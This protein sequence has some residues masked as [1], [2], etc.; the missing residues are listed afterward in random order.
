MLRM[1][2]PH[3]G[4]RASVSVELAL[5]SVLF[6]LPLFGG[7]ADLTE[8]IS[9]QAQANTALRALYSFAW[10]D[11]ADASTYSNANSI[12]GLINS[13]SIHPLS[14]SQNSTIAVQEVGQP[15]GTTIPVTNGSFYYVC[16]PTGATAG[17]TLTQSYSNP[18]PSSGYT[19]QI[20]AAYQVTST[21]FLPVPMPFVTN[22]QFTV[23]AMGEVQV[24]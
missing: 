3:L 9:A 19:T 20:W 15:A 22:G 17:G 13:S 10:A 23:T 12:V 14:F 16:I 6:L 18:C 5:V 21:V 1:N 2:R 24:E 11:P 4:K 8:I 7:G